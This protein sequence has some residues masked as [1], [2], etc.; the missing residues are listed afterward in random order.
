MAVD[1]HVR[2]AVAVVVAVAR[3]EVAAGRSR[4]F[5]MTIISGDDENY[6]GDRK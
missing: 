1:S 2:V 6:K 5:Y 3:V 4:Y